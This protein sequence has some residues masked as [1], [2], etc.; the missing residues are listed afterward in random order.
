[1]VWTKRGRLAH[2]VPLPA[3]FFLA[4][5]MFGFDFTTNPI[6]FWITAISTIGFTLVMIPIFK[7]GF[8]GLTAKDEP[9][10]TAIGT[11]CQCD[12]HYYADGECEHCQCR[13][14]QLKP[15]SRKFQ[16]GV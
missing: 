7:V 1:M 2:I 8:L 10:K 4:I 11:P 13:K 3:L 5:G 14:I 9:Q 12:C 6:T 15:S 16:R